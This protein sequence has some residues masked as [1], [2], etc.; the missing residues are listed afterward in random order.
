[1][2]PFE[3]VSAASLEQAVG[4]LGHE[5][6]AVLAGG[7]E[8]LERMKGGLVRPRRLVSI[9]RIEGISGVRPHAEG[10]LRLGALLTLG[11][12]AAEAAVGWELVALSTAAQSIASPQVRNLA[13]LGGNLCQRTPPG[14]TLA[15]LLI[16]LGAEIVLVGPQGEWR[17]P[18]A[19]LYRPD[20]WPPATLCE[21][22]SPWTGR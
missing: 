16:A 15:P 4:L 12:L 14:S 8:L 18:L 2:P 3:Y 21:A 7:T 19:E 13:T 22:A 11:E 17:L 20:G 10:G 9:R 5:G 6:A 1:M